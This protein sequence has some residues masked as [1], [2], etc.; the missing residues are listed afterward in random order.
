MNLLV[1]NATIEAAL[2]GETGKG[3]A[4]LAHE[5]KELAKV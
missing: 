3:F 5:M 4:I 1:R 2:L